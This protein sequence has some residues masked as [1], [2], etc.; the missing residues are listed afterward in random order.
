M[1]YI[2]YINTCVFTY[3]FSFH[4]RYMNRTYIGVARGA[5]GVMTPP[6]F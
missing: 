4:I 6:N 5:Q 2:N 3:R 1:L